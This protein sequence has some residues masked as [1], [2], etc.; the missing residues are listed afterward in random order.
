[1]E[2]QVDEQ[3]THQN[4]LSWKRLTIAAVALAVIFGTY[5]LYKA[6]LF[7]SSHQNILDLQEGRS[8]ESRDAWI[9][10]GKYSGGH[11][12]ALGILLISPFLSRERFWYYVILL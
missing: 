4:H 11:Y 5:P 7:E 1:M 3:P 8:E 9:A 10:F 2:R 12:F 6:T